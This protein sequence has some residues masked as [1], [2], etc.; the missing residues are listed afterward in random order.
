MFTI[1][2][3]LYFFFLNANNVPPIFLQQ[4]EHYLGGDAQAAKTNRSRNDRTSSNDDPATN[5]VAKTDASGA[6]SPPK[7]HHQTAGGGG[8]TKRRG[9]GKRRGGEDGHRQ[10][11]APSRSIQGSDGGGHEYSPRGRSEGA[12]SAG[13]KEEGSVRDYVD[14]ARRAAV[15]AC[16]YREQVST[17]QGCSRVVIRPAG[18]AN[19]LSGSRR[20]GR[21]GSEVFEASQVGSAALFSLRRVGSGHAD[22]IRPARSGL[23]PEIP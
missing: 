14:S 22:Q 6:K 11:K 16:M 12:H 1:L 8:V 17:F 13:A 3:S 10:K 7:K 15:G 19:R 4:E 18:G 9:R 20:S 23:T 5:S 2:V 21:V